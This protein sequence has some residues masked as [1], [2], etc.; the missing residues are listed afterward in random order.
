MNTST[1]FLA[2]VLALGVAACAQTTPEQAGGSGAVESRAVGT[3]TVN[4]YGCTPNDINCNNIYTGD[5]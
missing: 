4:V 2:A 3:P 1:L 5:N